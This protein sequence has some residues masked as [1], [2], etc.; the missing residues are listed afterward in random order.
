VLAKHYDSGT[1][2]TLVATVRTDAGQYR[3]ERERLVIA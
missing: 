3:S 1:V 2:V